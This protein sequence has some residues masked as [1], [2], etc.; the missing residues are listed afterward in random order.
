M[1]MFA[2]DFFIDGPGAVLGTTRLRSYQGDHLRTRILFEPGAALLG[3]AWC[4]LSTY[5]L[6]RGADLDQVWHAA[7]A[8]WAGENPYRAIGPGGPRME[9]DWVFYYSLS[10]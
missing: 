8:L 3:V 5:T 6:H 9:W 1:L 7:R 2:D 10:C 4:T